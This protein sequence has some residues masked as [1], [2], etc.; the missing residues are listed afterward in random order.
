MSNSP[1]ERPLRPK[2]CRKVPSRENNWT[3][4]LSESATTTSSPS[5]ESATPSGQLKS[6]LALPFEPM[7]AWKRSRLKSQSCERRRVVRGDSSA[8]RVPVAL[9]A[10]SAWKR[11]A[12]RSRHA[13][14]G[15][16]SS[17]SALSTSSRASRVGGTNG[18]RISAPSCG[19]IPSR[20]CGSASSHESTAERTSSSDGAD[21]SSA[22]STS[23]RSWPGRLTKLARSAT[24][25]KCRLSRPMQ[26]SATG[27]QCAVSEAASS[28]TQFPTPAER[29]RNEQ[30]SVASSSTSYRSAVR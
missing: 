9:L 20:P 18:Q 11:Y 3:R 25:P 26:C 28:A 10:C 17:S 19:S 27:L 23:S 7:A 13:S 2:A 12:S 30:Q 4:W 29:F 8:R 14:P 16:A 15:K 5:E 21:R 24:C 1:A 22:C 6:P